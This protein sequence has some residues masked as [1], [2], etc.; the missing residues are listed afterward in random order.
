MVL[1]HVVGHIDI[2]PPILVDVDRQH[3]QA[4]SVHADLFFACNVREST[5]SFVVQQSIAGGGK[6]LRRADINLAVQATDSMVGE[7]PVQVTHHKQFRQPVAV[8]VRR[9]GRGAPTVDDGSTR[10]GNVVKMTTVILQQ[11]AATKTRHEEVWKTV[12]VVIQHDRAV[13]IVNRV[14]Q[15]DK[16]G[17]VGEIP[18]AVVLVQTARASLDSLVRDVDGSSGRQENIQVS[19]DIE[20]DQRNSTAHGFKNGIRIGFPTTVV[21]EANRRL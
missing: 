1:H 21:L 19:I 9:T 3:A 5:V 17:N 20:V 16:C 8:K 18:F 2:E 7:T 15:P 11:P 6:R 10:F 4:F 13:R 12:N 14:R